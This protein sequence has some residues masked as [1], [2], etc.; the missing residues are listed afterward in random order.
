MNFTDYNCKQA[1]TCLK[2]QGSQCE[3]T[4]EC[5]NNLEC[6]DGICN[7]NSTVTFSFMEF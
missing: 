3:Q 2:P 5:T 7:C 4:T 1:N 6:L